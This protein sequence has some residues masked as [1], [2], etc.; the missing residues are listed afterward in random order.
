M[1][2]SLL[3]FPV[4]E[5][6]QVHPE[7]TIVRIGETVILTC[8]TGRGAPPP[9]VHWE[10]DG[11]IFKGGVQNVKV[12]PVKDQPMVTETKMTLELTA[13]DVVSGEFVCSSEN[14]LTKVS[15]RSNAG[16]VQSAG[17][18]FYFSFKVICYMTRNIF[19]LSAH[20]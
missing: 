18:S 14:N 11:T 15:Y 7:S 2:L 1:I 19:F 8:I 17:N 12:I 20:I 10:K 4:L 6:F 9:K 5:K 16:V 3:S 13:N